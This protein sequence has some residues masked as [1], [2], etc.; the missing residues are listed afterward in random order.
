[1]ITGAL[2]LRSSVVPEDDRHSGGSKAS[3]PTS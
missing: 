1:L 2:W 3:A